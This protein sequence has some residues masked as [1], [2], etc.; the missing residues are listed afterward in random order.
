ML[1]I[2]LTYFCSSVNF[3]VN[4]EISADYCMAICETDLA[5]CGQIDL[6]G[7]NTYASLAVADAFQHCPLD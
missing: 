4:C 3:A 5:A 2:S 7:T 1:S 6:S